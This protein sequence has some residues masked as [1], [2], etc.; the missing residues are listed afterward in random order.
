[1]CFASW[2]EERA[3]QSWKVNSGLPDQGKISLR[4]VRRDV[5]V[6]GRWDC[7]VVVRGER[8]GRRCRRSVVLERSH[9]SPRDSLK[10]APSPVSN[11]QHPPKVRENKC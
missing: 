6:C 2:A 7:E 10:D 11:L 1:L 8:D 4:D 3:W 5:V 9:K